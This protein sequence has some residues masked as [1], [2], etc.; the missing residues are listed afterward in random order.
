MTG[1][2]SQPDAETACFIAEA[3]GDIT[4]AYSGCTCAGG[5]K[6]NARASEDAC[7]THMKLD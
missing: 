4:G 2:E 1:K 3:S 7:S 6:L 5:N